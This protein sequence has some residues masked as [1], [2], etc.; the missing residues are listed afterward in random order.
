MKQRTVLLRLLLLLIF[1]GC[2]KAG[3]LIPLKEEY[4][5]PG[6]QFFPEGIAYDHSAA[7]FYTGST[8]NGDILKV[9]VIT[10]A[11]SLFSPGATKNRNSATGMKVDKYKRLWV[12]G[13]EDNKVHVLDKDG[14]VLR[15]WDTKALYGSGFIN[16][17]ALDDKYA[18]FTDSREQHIYRAEISKDVPE[19]LELWFEFTNNEIPY[20][21]GFNA[22]GAVLTR[23]GKYLIIV[24][25]ASGKLY[26]ID[27]KTKEVIEI[28]LNEPITA[29]D[30]LWLDGR[31]LYASRNSFNHIRKPPPSRRSAGGAD[32]T[33][34]PAPRRRDC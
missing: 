23:D 17:V 34:R 9:D 24:I 19:E 11:V 2:K 16:D 18:Y 8:T 13:G 1:L 7:V 10:G 31:N 27:R 3:D 5:L 22:N 33:A 4:P 32:P 21:Q 28:M 26:R 14:A 29:S 20:V 25:S 12:C 30:G 15:T 6:D